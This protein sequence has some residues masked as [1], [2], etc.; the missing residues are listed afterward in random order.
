MANKVINSKNLLPEFFRTDKNS[1]FLSSTIDQLIQP[2]AL[3]RIDG[4]VG[5]TLTPTYVSTSDV[6]IAESLPLRR[7][8]QLEPALVVKDNTGEVKD[9]IGLDDLVNEI[10]NNNGTVNNFDRLFRSKYYSFDPHIDLDK[11]VN[12][13]EYFWLDVG[14]PSVEI[15]GQTRNTTST[16]TVKN[17]GASFIFGPDIST[18]NPLITLYRGN[19]YYFEIDSVRNFYIKTSPTMGETNLYTNGVTNNGIKIGTIKIVVDESTPDTLFYTSDGGVFSQGQFNIQ[20]VLPDSP[21]NVELE[22]IGKKNFISGNGIAL[23][24]GLKVKFEGTILPESYRDKEYYVEGVGESIKLIDCSLFQSSEGFASRYNDNFD[25]TSFD[26]Y[27]FNNFKTLSITPEYVTI[28]RA[29]KDLNPW[30]RYN[31]WFHSDVIKATA[32]ALNQIPVYPAEKRARR[33]IIE[34]KADIQL[35]NFGSIGIENVDFIDTV[36]TDAFSFVEGSAG[37]YVDG[38]EEPLQQ[39]QRVIFSADN[40]SIVRSKIYRVNYLVING[41]TRLELQEDS[42]P[43]IGSVLSVN[44]GVEN[45][46]KSWWFNGDRWIY[47]QQHTQLNQA[48]LFD[49]FDI[50]GY[51]YSDINYYSSNFSG[52][53]IFGYDIGTGTADPILGFPLKY[54]N[55]V[56]V[57]SYLFKNFFNTE[58]ISIF[59]DGQVQNT[60]STEI[61]YCKL[62]DKFVNVWTATEESP[63]PILQFQTTVF[64]TSTIEVTAIDTPAVTPFNL[65]VFVDNIL[66]YNSQYG[67]SDYYKKLQY[68]TYTIG[69][70]FIVEFKEILP[71]GSNV[72]FKIYTDSPTNSNG[73]YEP[74]LSL[75]NNP[76]NGPIESITLSEMTDH[77]YTMISKIDNFSGILPGKSNLRDIPDIS[78]YGDRLISNENPIAF[79]Q[80]FIGKKENDL[81]GSLTKACDHYNQ[82]KM[83]F[84][85]KLAELDDQTKPIENFDL[86]LKELNANRDILSPYYQSDMVGYGTDK[87]TRTWSIVDNRSKIYSISSDFSLTAL[88]ARSVLVYRNGIQLLNGIDYKFLEN[89]SSIEILS[90]LS[91]GDTIEICDYTNTDGSFIPPTPT[92]LGLYPKFT[93]KIYT[94]DTYTSGP[95]KVIQGHDGSITVAYNDYRDDII[96]EFE[97]RVYNNIKCPYNSNLFDILDI[98][99]GIFRNNKYSIDEINQII[100]GDFIKWAAFYGIEYSSNPTFDQENSFTWNY[101]GSY[102]QPLDY[103]PEGSWRNVYKYFYDTDRP[104]SHP[105]EMLG[106]SEQPNW[107]ENEYGPAP[108]TS[109][110]EILWGDL[111]LGLIKQGARAG[112]NSVYARPGLMTILPVD[113]HGNLVPPYNI[114]SPEDSILSNITSYN[115]RQGWSVGDQGQAETAWRRSSYWPFTVQKLL[116][117]T[118]PSS[119]AS[120]MYDPSRLI[121]NISGQWIYEPA[122]GFLN[123]KDVLIHGDNGTLTNGYSVYLTEINLQRTRNY[124]QELKED[125][126]NLNLNLFYKVGGFVSKDKLRILIDSINPTSSSPG[127]ILP[128]EDYNLILNTSNPISLNSISGIIVQ[129]SKGKF[130][131]K[132]YDSS[133]PY[134]TTYSCIRNTNTPSLTV[135]GKSEAFVEWAPSTSGGASGLAAYDTA[136]AQSPTGGK[137]YQQGQIVSY[138]N[139]FYRVKTSHQSGSTFD[140]TYFQ[141]M[142]SLPTVGG[143]TVQ[144]FSRFEKVAQKIPYGTEFDKI[145]EVY[146]LIVGYGAWLE[147]QGFIL[148]QFEP[149]VQ[150]VIDWNFTAKEFLYWTSQNWAENSIITLSPFASQLQYKSSNSVVDNIFN[151]FYEYSVLKADGTAFDPTKLSVNRE[152]GLCTISTVNTT[153]GIYFI[154][155]RSVQKEHAMVFNNTTM[156]NDI[157]YDIE[158]GYRQQRMKL[159]GFR[160]SNWDGDYFSPGFVYDEAKISNWSTYTKYN[161]GDVVRFNGK[162]YS[163]DRTIT[164]TKSFDF[165]KWVLLKDKPTQDLLPNFDYKIN[166]FEDFYSLDIDN[167][168]T[169]QQKMAQ[170]L[171]G[172]TPRSY[173]N[174]IFTNPIAQYKFYQGFIKEKGTKNSISKLAKST[175]Q[176][177]QGELDFTEE[178]AFR[179]GHFGSYQ[180]YKEIEFPLIEGSFFE[181]P[182]TV[183]FTETTSTN[184]LEFQVTPNDLTIIPDGYVSTGT[185][186]LNTDTDFEFKLSSAGYVRIDDVLATALNENSL[187][188]IANNRALN[189]GDYIWLGYKKNKDWDVYR[190]S[191]SKSR[192]INV[193]DSGVENEIIFETDIMHKLSANQVISISQFNDQLNGVYIVKRIVN[194]TQFAVTT[195]IAI[196]IQQAS[197]G[198]LFKFESARFKTFDDLPA[199]S[200]LLGLCNGSKLWVDSDGSGKWVVYEK[201]RNY[202][203]SKFTQ[204]L[205]VPEQ[206]LGWSISKP[207]SLSHYAVGSPNYRYSDSVYGSVSLYKETAS[208]SKFLLRYPLSLSAGCYDASFSTVTGFG[209][210]VEYTDYNFNGTG[211]GLIFAGAP[212]VSRLKSTDPIGGVRFAI[213]NSDVLPSDLTN[214]GAVK[215]SSVNP[216]LVDEKEQCILL[217]PAPY[218]YENFGYS[219]YAQNNTSSFVLAVGAPGIISTGTGKVYAFN[220]DASTA[221]VGVSLYS[222][223]VPEDTLLTDITNGAQFGYSIDG[224]TNLIAIGAPGYKQNTG[225]VSLHIVNV[226]ST[227]T[228][229]LQTIISPYGKQGRFGYQIKMSPLGDYLFI[230]APEVRNSDQSFGRIAVYKKDST[231]YYSKVQDIFN[232]VAFA[233]MKFGQDFDVNNDASNLVVTAIGKNRYF[234]VVF[235]YKDGV[236]GG[237][238][239]FD[240]KSTSFSDSIVDTG[241]AYVYSRKLENGKFKLS[242][243]LPSVNS[244]PGTDY[245]Y[246]VAVGVNS[247]FVGSPA[248]NTADIPSTVYHYYKTEP[249]EDNWKI[250]RSQ[251]NIVDVNA[252]QRICLIDTFTEE[253]TDYLD[254]IDPLKGKIAGIAEQDL[255]FKS[256]FDPAVYSI[257]TTGTIIDSTICWLDSHVGELWWDISTVKYMW[258]EQGEALYRKNNWGRIFPGT[259]IDIY[260]W[261]GSEYLPSEWSTL[262]D[263]PA[264]LVNG[265]SGQPKYPNN[266]VLSIRQVYD[267]I[268]NSFSNRY[269]YW[270]KNKLTVPNIPNRRTSAYE[271]TSM[272]TDPSAYGLKFAAITSKDSMILSNIGQTLV[273]DRISVNIAQDEKYKTNIPRH[274]EWLL[275]QEGSSKSMPNVL[276]EKK[277]LDSLLGHDNLGNLVPDPSLSERSRYGIEIRPQQTLFKN[278][279]EALRNIVEFANSVLIKNRITGNFSFTNLNKQEEL[280][281]EA[282]NEYDQIVEDNTILSSIDTRKLKSGILTCQ[283]ENGKIISVEIIDPGFGYKNPPTVSIKSEIGA[284]GEITVEIDPYGRISSTQIKNSGDGY[285]SSPALNVRPYTVYV[286]ADST[287]NGKW[288]RFTFDSTEKIWNR[289]HTQKFNTPLYWKYVDW[290]SDTYNQYLDYSA[291]VGDVYNLQELVNVER[292]QYVKVKNGGLGWYIIL[293]KT[294][295]AG[296]TFSNDYNIVYSQN[297]TIQILD[298]I[299]NYAGNNFGFDQVKNYDQ[300]LY[301][302]TPDLELQYLML[303]LK[304]DIFIN[305]LL[306]NWNLLFFTAVKYALS[307]QKLLDWAFKTSFINVIN[308]AGELNQPSVY[309]LESSDNFE[310]YLKEVKPY[311]TNIRSFTTDYGV[312][313]P[314][315]TF[316]SDFDLPT[317]FNKDTNNYYNIEIDS[318]ISKNEFT[319]TNTLT[320]VY[321]WKAWTDNYTFEVGSI[322]VGYGGSGYTFTPVVNIESADGDN[323][324]GA[325]AV[326]YISSGKVVAIEVTNSG[327]GYVKPPKVTIKGGGDTTLIPAVAYARLFNG[328]I[329]STTV[330][331]KFDRTSRGPENNELKVTD[332][333]LCDGDTYEFVLKWFSEQDKSKILVTL[334]G[335]TIL[336]FDYTLKCYKEEYN[337]YNKDFCKVIFLNY[338]PKK[339]QLLKISYL[340]NTKILN[341][342][343]RI[344][345]YYTATSGMPGFDLGQLMEGIEYPK[346]QLQG[347][348]FSYNASWDQ[349]G[350][351]FGDSSWAE[352]LGSII[353]SKVVEFAPAGTDTFVLSDLTGI[354]EG[355]YANVISSKLNTFDSSTPVHVI[356]VDTSTNQVEFSSPTMLDVFAD[357]STYQVE[358]WTYNSNFGAL[359]SVIEG[360]DLGYTTALGINPSDLII[361]G[362]RFLTPNTSYG[363]EELVPGG[364]ADSLGINVYTKNSEGSPIVITSF[365]DILPGVTTVRQLKIVPQNTRAISVS[366]NNAILAYNET[367][368]FNNSNEFSINWATNEIIVPPQQVLGK[369]GYTIVN[370]GGGISDSEVDVIDS[371]SVVSNETEAQVQ[372]LSAYGTIQSAYVTVNG[373]SIP[374]ISDPSQYGYMLTYSNNS[375]FRAAVNVYNLPEGTTNTVTAWFFGTYNKYFNEIKE[376]VFRINTPY[377]KTFTLSYPPGNVEPIVAGSMVEYKVLS[378]NVRR[379][380]IPPH[381]DYYEV[382]DPTVT[383]FLINNEGSFSFNNVRVYVNGTEIRKG[384]DY[385]ISGSTVLINSG[386][387]KLRDMIAIV[388]KPTGADRDYEY[389]ITSNQLLLDF[390]PELP[391]EVTV[392]TYNNNDQM[393]FRTE[394]FKGTSIRRYKIS[395]PV[396]DESYVWVSVNGIP[397]AGR[398]DYEVLDDQVTIQIS[399]EHQHSSSDTIV[400]T[401]LGSANLTSNILGYRIFNDILNRTHFKRLAKENSTYLTKELRFTDTEIHVADASVFTNPSIS[402]KIPGVV[403]IDGE[404][405]EF[406]EVDGNVLKKLRRSTLGTAPSLRSEINTKVIDQGIDQ[407]VP[408]TESI[409]KQ[410]LFTVAGVN[411][412]TINTETTVTSVPIVNSSGGIEYFSTS[413]SNGIILSTDPTIPAKD[414][415]SIY[416]GGRLLKKAATFQQD[417][418]LAYD[419]PM[420]DFK[421]IGFISSE[422]LLPAADVIGTAY[423]VTSTNQVWVY[424]NSNDINAQNGYEFNG[425]TYVPPE[426]TVNASNQQITLNIQGGVQDSLSLVIMKKQFE[427][428]KVWNTEVTA[429]ETLSLMDSITIPARFL[430]AKPAEL[431]DKYYYGGDPILTADSGFAFVDGN[432]NPLR[433]GI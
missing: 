327:S 129:K 334:D 175:I 167:F 217:S 25:A 378:T 99:P 178:W 326:A 155:I 29:S 307:E 266:N 163:A 115:R 149:K 355:Q 288:T 340:K 339:G 205:Y 186:I 348:E 5:S 241:S 126:S 50:N 181:N 395:R 345:N 351:I 119:Y 101:T 323:G 368:A 57:G 62:G 103:K 173:L 210:C 105:W 78:K 247:I 41:K 254:T 298:S 130:V 88:S 165:T 168:D 60:I 91:V 220:I 147:D 171:I 121:K 401:S 367:T 63:I 142:P 352:D 291:T 83:A 154:E 227:A 330:G 411:T 272:I 305:E 245:G 228:T 179:T 17:V 283:V 73:F 406:L 95:T 6:Y 427:R 251:D 67:T 375:S 328:K 341:A 230:S 183:T 366:F 15:I 387:L 120:L 213:E 200:D 52:N 382:T 85:K 124:I 218:N 349:P 277:M 285:I 407:T 8:Y 244:N 43:A 19:T 376:E 56:G 315:Q 274:T 324:V 389:D 268:T 354:K 430:K 66:F 347:L 216:L 289:A 383:S 134:F 214:E 331:M 321:P 371:A 174:N 79:A 240:S 377:D 412:Y 302:Q 146:D 294:N 84:L 36:M 14:P 223:I 284:G 418:N 316:T 22:I 281:K 259:S 191:V 299:W 51:S 82:F 164:G 87:I 182:Q 426:F 429:N 275:L 322:D 70:R 338:I 162:Y 386:I 133:N 21:L 192:V 296:G 417:K 423:V 204:E 242:Q 140:P 398:D 249:L 385:S 400:V 329:K 350:Y 90:E 235:D 98:F 2:P 231:G 332:E 184:S 81:I 282:S 16:Y 11:F 27:P 111:E 313:E 290:V 391:S 198:L 312:T 139:K 261:V 311:H 278:R 342:I 177:L 94:D 380:L 365:V 137:F 239:T 89:D 166:Q 106:F 373:H 388:D 44:F 195:S 269:Y 141:S 151:S 199:D 346:T 54:R 410:T 336:G 33:P 300:T 344:V 144:T 224:F 221:T 280:P 301:D 110:N 96:L 359:D 107:W 433:E 64:S 97:K 320:N 42:A 399:D 76:L 246:S 237:L 128:L 265:I 263:T 297:G 159:T 161:P 215:I 58:N 405:I 31:R 39:G 295:G 38:A 40:D 286:L 153:D 13:Q 18:E 156:F 421:N 264:G 276:L 314:S 193:T 304:K 413:T 356:R 353:K 93:P 273:G 143:V 77:V 189:D 393:F 122:Q 4:Y 201:I 260:E 225:I 428:S 425:L 361:S 45:A 9:V 358:F 114:I 69:P 357:T 432:N 379:Q 104:H 65:E 194:L 190:Y 306:V 158:T 55:S 234:T 255:N 372:S 397:L 1:K 422:K 303:A 150:T 206:K 102:Y 363:P 53:K 267:N 208:S 209:H 61:T 170:H 226:A 207:T 309:K 48:P 419:S 10:K 127:V 232:P 257:G 229:L 337:G 135:G 431:P 374:R 3:E 238:T 123:V 243:E 80:L 117:L 360:G 34:F 112:I 370:V 138:N 203:T 424:T 196:D 402:K 308:K 47:A 152:N 180:S 49:L 172:Y 415:I 364:V 72:L 414:Q 222:T 74:P 7:N 68:S 24:N 325:S 219:V 202:K 113:N 403:I 211:F 212:L 185:F 390:N 310:D 176:N 109:G 75:T 384:F 12:F 369:L 343:D 32:E 318:N 252:V 35:F 37:Y 270:V 420:G 136:T 258:Y 23:T 197:I 125:Q 271:I 333:F 92:K 100:Q 293:E 145:Q 256:N 409:L 253:I 46:G 188:D 317:V 71:A 116:A 30:T 394:T 187:L 250:L 59:K 262:A 169:A 392:V 108:Y 404:R 28:N 118:S 131:I 335:T 381:I 248:N 132:G 157:I 279:L 292:G 20:S 408:F 26:S 396:L 362:D 287:Y 148:N 86:A 160:T 233:G 319:V 236:C 416:Y